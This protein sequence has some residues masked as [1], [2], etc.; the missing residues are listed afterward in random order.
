VIPPQFPHRGF[1][2]T[3]LFVLVLK[4][5]EKVVLRLHIFPNP[6]KLSYSPGNGPTSFKI[7][8]D[9]VQIFIR[10]LYT[11]YGLFPSTSSTGMSYMQNKN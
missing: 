2:G 4:A 6:F 5:F 11:L 1:S 9:H 7:H 3:N 8:F 10:V